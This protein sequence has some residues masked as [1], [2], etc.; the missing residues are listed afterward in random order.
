MRF[1]LVALLLLSA[2]P[3]LAEE[4]RNPLDVP[5]PPAPTEPVPDWLKYQNHYAGEQNDLANPHRSS[6]EMVSWSQNKAID[7]MSFTPAE[8]NAQ[9]MEV[10]KFFTPRGWA[11]YAT[12]MRDSRLAEMV[13]Q[14]RYAVSTIVNGDASI[15]NSGSAEGSYHWIV[16]VPVIVTFLRPG[17]EDAQPI[18]GGK[19]R[20]T[21]QVG[22]ITQKEGDDGLVIEG[23]KVLAQ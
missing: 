5:P 19:F 14:Q 3:A 20:L 17:D 22:R 9:L 13:R 4:G 10:K 1:L 6:E 12:W 2:A 7:A 23:W 8:F 15:T 18:N 11:E 16:D 21:L